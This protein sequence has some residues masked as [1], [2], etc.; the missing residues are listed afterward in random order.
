MT[1]EVRS[2]MRCWH[3]RF[4]KILRLWGLVEILT[5][6]FDLTQEQIFWWEH[7]T[8]LT[9]VSWYIQNCSSKICLQ[10][11]LQFNTYR[12][13]KSG[14]NSFFENDFY[15]LFESGNIKVD[16]NFTFSDVPNTKVAF[17]RKKRVNNHI[18]KGLFKDKKDHKTH[19][20][21]LGK[22]EYTLPAKFW[23]LVGCTEMLSW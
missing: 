20:Q 13:D 11:Q 23:R 19:S 7:P 21:M 10:S 2:K 18:Y 12:I 3:L 5:L 16:A 4:F 15:I 22:I 17:K 1:E 8:I 6:K 14:K 9:I